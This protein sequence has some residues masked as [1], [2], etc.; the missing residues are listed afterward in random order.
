MLPAEL[1]QNISSA[2]LKPWAGTS[3]TLSF[4]E[5]KAEGS[6]CAVGFARN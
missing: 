1:C 4:V 5:G 2:D 3:L 6:Y